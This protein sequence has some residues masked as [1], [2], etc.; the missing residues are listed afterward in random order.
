MVVTLSAAERAA[1][2]T[3]RTMQQTLTGDHRPAGSNEVGTRGSPTIVR[4]GR[5]TA[6]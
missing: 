2:V 4:Q 6:S 1:T 5:L 3:T